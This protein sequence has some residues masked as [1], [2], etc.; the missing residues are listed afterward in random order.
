MATVLGF[1]I[2]I[3]SNRHHLSSA[4]IKIA[5][6][7]LQ[8]TLA[9]QRP[10]C[11]LSAVLIET[12]DQICYHTNCGNPPPCLSWAG[13]VHRRLPAIPHR[14]I[15]GECLALREIP[16]ERRLVL[17]YL[18]TWAVSRASWGSSSRSSLTYA[19]GKRSKPSGANRRLT[20]LC[21]YSITALCYLASC[22]G[23]CSGFPH[24]YYIER[25]AL[26]KRFAKKTI[27]R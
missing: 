25:T 22:C 24:L 5:F 16:P 12:S 21:R 17:R 20:A 18:A 19:L 3:I 11:R 7:Q 4:L 1:H 26:V 23:N 13:T 15:G 27:A 6:S 8:R 9:R 10:F 14:R 2:F